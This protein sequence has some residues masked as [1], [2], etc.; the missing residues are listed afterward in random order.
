VNLVK[1]SA[2]S[3]LARRVGVLPSRSRIAESGRGGIFRSDRHSL[4]TLLIPEILQRFIT[5]WRTADE[6]GDWPAHAARITTVAEG[7][8]PGAC[9]RFPWASLVKTARNLAAQ[10]GLCEG[11]RIPSS[12]PVSSRKKLY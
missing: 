10:A 3:K 8:G 7:V 9:P 6:N 2:T 5:A 1:N 4:L 11:A 12:A